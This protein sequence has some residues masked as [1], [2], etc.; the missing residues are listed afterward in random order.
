[1]SQASDGSGGVIEAPICEELIRM[2]ELTD[3]PSSAG[4]GGIDIATM[5]AARVVIHIEIEGPA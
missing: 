1:M 4:T 3:M 2:L 5:I